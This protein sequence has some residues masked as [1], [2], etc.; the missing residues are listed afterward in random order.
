M[1]K[2]ILTFIALATLWSCQTDEQYERLNR[3]PKNPTQVRADFLFTSA[4]VNLADQMAS[5]NVNFNVFR[6]LAQYL[7]TTTY[8]D[9]PN[10]RINQRNI[11]D[12]HWT[13]LYRDVIY[14]LQDAKEIVNATE[15]LTEG[16]KRARIGQIEVIEVYAW[17]VL[18][19]TFGDI[20]YTEALDADI[21]LPVYDEAPVIYADLISRLSN[22][23]E[24]LQA[25]QGFVGADVIYGGDM[26]KWSKFAN[27]LLLRLGMRLADVN[28]SLSMEAVNEALMEGV[29]TSLDDSALVVYQSSP[30]NTNP[31]WVDL[32]QSGRS[33][34]LA[35]N[36]I[37]DIMNALDDPRRTA[38]F[39]DNLIGGYVGGIYGASNSFPEYT[40]IGEMFL[41][42]T[43]P[44][45]LLDY[46][47]VEFYQAEAAARGG[48]SVTGTAE[49]HYNTAITASI[50]Y[51]GGTDALAQAY[52]AQPEVSYDATNWEEQIG[53][54]FWIAMYD[55]PFEGWSVWRK[56]DAPELNQAADTEDA[57]PL[58]YTYPINEQ[59]LNEANYIDAAAAIGG[60]DQQT[61]LFWD[62]E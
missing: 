52:I 8:L 41:D 32:V 23:T 54:Q 43:L 51:Y 13:E 25:G 47:E 60:D 4:T 1:K 10:Y 53:T 38:Y 19:D 14:N 59:N 5:P 30:P 28:P 15:S 22:V 20:P 50:N 35:A 21:S 11:P 33:D 55:N 12:F 58:R 34:Y 61:S 37:V 3:D 9:E 42:P 6:F 7:T 36:T 40:H 18:V 24:D 45:I 2:Y 26:E 49:D 44:A 31:L 56:F 17:H 57:V 48:Y 46:P 27:S 16:E 29:F 39:D 62:V